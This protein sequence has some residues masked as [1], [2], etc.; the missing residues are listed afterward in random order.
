M[1]GE[2]R[3]ATGLCHCCLDVLSKYPQIMLDIKAD[4]ESTSSWSHWSCHYSEA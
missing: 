4:L 2:P 1:G 3:D